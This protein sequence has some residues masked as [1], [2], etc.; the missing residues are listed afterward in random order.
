MRPAASPSLSVAT[1]GTDSAQ[2]SLTYCIVDPILAGAAVQLSVHDSIVDGL[3]CAAIGAA[4]QA[5]GN[6]DLQRVT[7]LGTTTA[8]TCNA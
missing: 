2:V 7:V 8:A 3:G 5:V 6:L 1:S 4:G